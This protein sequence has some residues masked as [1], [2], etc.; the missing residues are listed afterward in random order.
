M[1][2]DTLKKPRGHGGEKL[3][4]RATIITSDAGRVSEPPQWGALGPRRL[5]NGAPDT[6]GCA[7]V[8][9]RLG[10]FGA[11]SR[12]RRP[13]AGPGSKPRPP[14]LRQPRR[15]IY[16]L[17][18]LAT[19]SPPPVLFFLVLLC[20]RGVYSLLRLL[21]SFILLLFLSF[22]R[23]LPLLARLRCLVPLAPLVFHTQLDCANN[24]IN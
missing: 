9:W 2:L 3:V 18:S 11:L 13:V 14:A 1:A 19:T 7:R 5:L 16:C 10:G 4:W 23:F 17:L 15:G 21:F 24:T 6:N 8:H 12:G 20:Y 22:V